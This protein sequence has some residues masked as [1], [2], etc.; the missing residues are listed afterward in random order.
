MREGDPPKERKRLI[1]AKHI[2]QNESPKYANQ[3][4]APGGVTAMRGGLRP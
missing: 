4:A 1:P 2:P 3:I